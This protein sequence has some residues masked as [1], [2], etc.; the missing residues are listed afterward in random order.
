MRRDKTTDL[1]PHIGIIM[2]H[3]VGDASRKLAKTLMI[4]KC[5]VNYIH[6]YTTPHILRYRQIIVVVQAHS[7]LRHYRKSKC[8]FNR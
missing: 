2:L 3:Q 5:A 7:Q 4:L 8:K 6:M 1:A